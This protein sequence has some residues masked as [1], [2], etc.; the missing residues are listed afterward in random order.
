MF[1]FLLELNFVPVDVFP[2]LV[3]RGLL[4]PKNKDKEFKNSFAQKNGHRR[5]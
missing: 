5:L 2:Y 4:C 1:A 3:C